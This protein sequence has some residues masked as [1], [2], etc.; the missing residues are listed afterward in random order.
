MRVFVNHIGFDG[1][2]YKTAVLELEQEA[3]EITA[4]LEADNVER[5]H[6]ERYHVAVSGPERMAAT[7]SW[8]FPMSDGRGRTGLPDMLMGRHFVRRSSRSPVIS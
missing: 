6:G 4:W 1:T 7:T 5:H 8:T 3:A 2:D